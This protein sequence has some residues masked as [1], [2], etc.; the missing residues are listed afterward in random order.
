MSQ[1][2]ELEF[3]I[4]ENKRLKEILRLLL[5]DN[6]LNIIIQNEGKEAGKMPDCT[7]CLIKKF[8][9]KKHRN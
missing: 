9:I 5:K 2:K 7:G 6:N 3:L 1:M 8:N 4:R